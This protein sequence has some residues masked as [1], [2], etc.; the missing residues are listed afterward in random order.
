[1]SLQ[2][3]VS[4]RDTV[5]PMLGLLTSM[6]TLVCC[7]LPLVFVSLGLGAALAGLVSAAPWMVWLS[8]HKGWVFTVSGVMLLLSW[9]AVRRQRHAP[10][11]A[12]RRL[13]QACRRL[14]AI[15]WWLVLTA[16]ALWTV[17]FGVAIVLPKVLAA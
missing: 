9:T 4:W 12:D 7:V 3:S 2:P 17:G 1:M 8:V 11:P 15:S 5:L 16:T 10:C 13:A 14:R 6:G